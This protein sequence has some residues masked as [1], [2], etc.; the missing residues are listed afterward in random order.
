MPFHYFVSFLTSG[1]FIPKAAKLAEPW[2]AH[3]FSM[4]SWELFKKSLEGWGVITYEIPFDPHNEFLL[5]TMEWIYASCWH[6]GSSSSMAM[7]KL[8]GKHDESVAIE[9]TIEKLV[10]AYETDPFS[11]AS[12]AQ[13]REIMYLFPGEEMEGRQIPGSIYTHGDRLSAEWPPASGKIDR[14]WFKANA[15][16]VTFDHLFYKHSAFQYENEIRL[17]ISDPKP[18]PFDSEDHTNPKNGIYLKNKD[19]IQSVTISPYAPNWFCFVVKRVIKKFELTCNVRSS[20]LDKI[21]FVSDGSPGIN[22]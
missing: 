13:L 1:L 9:T 20:D 2:E 10:E 12:H 5:W 19:F 14:N 22:E 6:I 7:W 21:F 4:T 8:Y 11:E 18:K 3:T 16:N 17:L 15:M